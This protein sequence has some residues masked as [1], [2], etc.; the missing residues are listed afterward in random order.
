VTAIIA[1]MEN[2]N[3]VVLNPTDLP[4][5]RGKG[6]KESVKTMKKIHDSTLRNT[7]ANDIGFVPCQYEESEEDLESE[8]DS[9]IDPIDELEIYGKRRQGSIPASK[10]PSKPINH[11]PCV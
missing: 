7:L 6:S 10:S 3:P 1:I 2:A 8:D 9:T 4:T 5:R 11:L